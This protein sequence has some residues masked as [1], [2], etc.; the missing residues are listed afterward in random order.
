MPL[1]GEEGEDEDEKEEGCMFLFKRA[2]K[3]DVP[4]GEVPRGRAAPIGAVLVAPSGGSPSAEQKTQ[5]A[6]RKRCA[7]PTGHWT[8]R[9]PSVELLS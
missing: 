4:L 6:R 9:L 2:K 1:G 3:A 7:L 5:R 8:N